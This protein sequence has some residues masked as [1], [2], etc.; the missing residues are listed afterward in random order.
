[1]TQWAR[2]IFEKVAAGDLHEETALALLES[3]E[4]MQADSLPGKRKD[5]AIIGLSM[6]MPGAHT[7][8]QFWHNLSRKREC[9]GEYPIHRRRDSEPFIRTHTTLKTDE[10][11]YSIGGY[12]D[13]V[14]KFDY[15]FFQLSPMEAALMD[16][17]HRM[18]LESCWSAIEDAGYGGGRLQGSRTGVYIGHADWPLYGQYITK[19]QPSR[20]QM[21]G[22]GNTPSILASRI[23]YLLDLRGPSLLIDTACSS[24]LV[25]VH[26]ACK[27]IQNGDCDM[28]LTGGVKLCLMPVAGVFDIGIESSRAQTSAF[29]EGSD[30]TVWGEGAAALLL[31]PLDQALADR[32]HIYAVIKGSGMNQDGASVGITAPNAAAQE[33]VL[34][35]AW[36]DA[37]VHPESIALFEAHGTGTRL[38]DPIE[39]DGI[40]RAFQRYTRRKQFCAIG[41]V[42]TNIGHLDGL[43]GIAGLLKGI[44]ALRFKQLPPTLH[45]TRPN[46][47]IPFA[48]TPVYVQDRLADWESPDYPRRCGVSSFGFSG[49]NCHVVLEEAP[50]PDGDAQAADLRADDAD[51]LP[52]MFPVSAKCEESLQAWADAYANRIREAEEPLADICFTASTGRGHYAYRLVVTGKD[53]RE[54]ADKLAAYARNVHI[55]DGSY[56]GAHKEVAQAREMRAPGE[57]TPSE[58]REYSRKANEILHLLL[59]AEDGQERIALSRQLCEHY[60][61]GADVDWGLLYGERAGRKVRLP[62]YP[63][64]RLRCWMDDAREQ[65]GSAAKQ[66]VRLTGRPSGQYSAEE[67]LLG[68][69]WGE[70]LGLET[71]DIYDDFFE[72]GGNSIQAIRLEA[73]LAKLGVKLSAEQIEAE[74]CIQRL[75]AYISA[76]C[77]ANVAGGAEAA[78]ASASAPAAS[79]A[80]PSST[81]RTTDYARVVA[82]EH[83]TVAIS[84]IEPFNDVFFKN[85]FYNSLFPVVRHYGASILPILLNDLIV[86]A[87]N[88]TRYEVEYV[89]HRPDQAV[90]EQVGLQLAARRGNEQFVEEAKREIAAGRP[91]IVWV[92]AFELSI[93][94]DAYRKEHMDHTLL[95]YGYDPPSRQFLVIEHDRRENLSYRRQLVSYEDM[96]RGCR[97]FDERYFRSGEHAAT[98]YLISPIGTREGRMAEPE[99]LRAS[100][101]RS[102]AVMLSESQALQE[103]SESVLAQFV[104]DFQ[105][106][107]ADEAHLRACVEEWAD[108]LNQVMNSKQV[109]VYR[110]RQLLG[111]DHEL[112]QSADRLRKSWDTVRKGVVRYLYLPVFDAAALQKLADRL[113]ELPRQ[114]QQF[115]LQLQAA[116]NS[117]LLTT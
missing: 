99:E 92:D 85:C 26:T 60:V 72:I 106:A 54:L 14:D 15:D 32:D 13:E 100:C 91:V 79:A 69:I 34:C 12:L 64:R 101:A 87:K 61:R 29:D 37:G 50:D 86:F 30:G 31:K 10:I 67:R 45:F 65:T 76:E 25:A 1:M 2:L 111:E 44:A 35:R 46:R 7:L 74:R 27:A 22:V 42:K 84:G 40:R 63:F 41:S 36:E 75:A 109:E 95:I 107:V 116:M 5:I 28:A 112:V 93:R 19:T 66:P 70:L 80:Q 48:D 104:S 11:T 56:I 68:Q 21:A 23:S 59:D 71:L 20:I 113:Q 16:P 62:A 33:E 24:S 8:E 17:N 110:L 53:K 88:G 51:S 38:G 98:H 105:A 117:Y 81:V 90:F 52:Y 82:I 96:E 77:A 4:S 94:K 6:R 115:R 57:V 83:T 89:S 3:F 49:T 97:A 108:F 18:F 114:E 39:V 55:P 102:F 9:I 43:S 78:V 47:S 103:Q 73:D 58:R